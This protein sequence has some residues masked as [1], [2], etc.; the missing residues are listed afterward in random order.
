[1]LTTASP[2]CPLHLLLTWIMNEINLK[3]MNCRCVKNGN[4]S[5]LMASQRLQSNPSVGS[6]LTYEWDERCPCVSFT[7]H[8]YICNSPCPCWH[9]CTRYREQQSAA[10]DRKVGQEKSRQ[11]LEGSVQLVHLS[12]L[13]SFGEIQ[14][15]PD[16]KITGILLQ[17]PFQS[18][19]S[20]PQR[21]TQLIHTQHAHHC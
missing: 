10:T 1:M 18:I 9:D 3:W 14:L 21:H 16:R 12:E 15:R 4:D 6:V 2:C 13:V 11:Y 8:L 20:L 17:G 7:P 19:Q 5:Q